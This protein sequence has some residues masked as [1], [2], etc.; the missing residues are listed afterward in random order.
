MYNYKCD[1]ERQIVDDM[2]PPKMVISM[3]NMV[4]NLIP[5]WKSLLS[6]PDIINLAFKLPQKRQEVLYFPFYIYT[7]AIRY[8]F[9]FGNQ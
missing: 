6:G 4:T 2:K 8:D 5:S 9:V 1:D 3:M 7:S